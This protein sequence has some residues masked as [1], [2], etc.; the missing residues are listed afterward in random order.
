MQHGR[1]VFA[2]IN[3]VVRDMEAMIEFYDRLGVPIEPMIEPFAPHHRTLACSAV[4]DGF[5]FDVDST[6]FVPQ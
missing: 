4:V 6:A 1:P 3:L 2:Q 5:D